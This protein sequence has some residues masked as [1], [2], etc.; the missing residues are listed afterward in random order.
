M[1]N[2]SVL[3]SDFDESGRA[4]VKVEYG[5]IPEGASLLYLLGSPK[6]FKSARKNWTPSRCVVRRSHLEDEI[7]F[8]CTASAG[9][10]EKV[11]NMKKE[12]SEAF[13]TLLFRRPR[14][15]D[16]NWQKTSEFEFTPGLQ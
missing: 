1:G 9:D 7:I 4:P 2:G 14:H 3:L 5:D 11:V 15:G 13:S 12:R 6:I 10:G 8:I 16:S